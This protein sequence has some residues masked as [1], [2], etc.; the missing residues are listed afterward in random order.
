MNAQP[1]PIRTTVIYGLACGLLF[2][3]LAFCFGSILYWPKA[4]KLILWLYLAGYS[5][6]LLKWGSGRV[7][8]IIFPVTLLLATLFFPLP[9]SAFIF[10]LLGILSWIRSTICFQHSF[11]KA[12]VAEIV[13]CIGG[14]ILVVSFTPFSSICL[15]IGIFLFFLVQSIYFLIIPLRKNAFKEDK[16]D[17]FERALRRVESILGNSI[18]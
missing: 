4:L 17:P 7:L 3:P 14:A 1:R 16:I 10:L 18:Y 8:Q 5:L 11:F 9:L 15:A 6:F 12:I 2:A 13:V